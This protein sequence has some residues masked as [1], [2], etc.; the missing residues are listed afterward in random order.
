MV[1]PCLIFLILKF[2]IFLFLC[3]IVSVSYVVVMLCSFAGTE[4]FCMIC[5]VLGL[6]LF[7][8]VLSHSLHKA[9]EC[10]HKIIISYTI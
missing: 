3:C 10:G 2:T 5:L 1:M 4:M 7:N 9:L 8:H 6:I